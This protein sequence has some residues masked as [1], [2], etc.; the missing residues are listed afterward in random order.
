ML[1]PAPSFLSTIHQIAMKSSRIF[2]AV[3]VILLGVAYLL[4]IW[5]IQLE[6]PQYPEPIGLYIFVHAIRGIGDHDLDNINILNHYIGMKPIVPESIAELRLMPWILAGL[7]GL[8]LIAFIVPRRWLIATWMG[9]IAISGIVGL[10]DFN[11]WLVDYGTNLSPHAPIKIEGMTYKP[12]LL[13]TEQ[14]LNITA[15]SY[16][17]WGGYAVVLALVAGAVALWCSVRPPTVWC[18]ASSDGSTTDVDSNV[19]PIVLPLLFIFLTASSC[20]PSPE[21]IRFGTDQCELCKMTISDQRFGAEI[22]V[23]TGKAYKFDSIECMVNYLRTR[24]LDSASVALLLVTDF[25]SPGTLIDAKSAVYL[26]SEQVPSPMGADVSA[27]ATSAA[28]LALQLQHGGDVLSW[29]QV[30]QYIASL[31]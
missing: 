26:R 25:L 12:P 14:L 24:Q 6:A 31:E 11:L 30:Q 10:Y 28:A 23:K 22:V 1:K 4:P 17:S 7:I 18:V 13:G 16:P 8:G 29:E 3:G 21:P 20:T 2:V 27:Y 19:S 5:R 15:H 9:A